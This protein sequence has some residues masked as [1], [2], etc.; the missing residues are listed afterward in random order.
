MHKNKR[1]IALLLTLVMLFSM[2]PVVHAE[3]SSVETIVTVGTGGD[4]DGL[5]NAYKG[6]AKDTSINGG[7]VIFELLGDVTGTGNQNK[8]YQGTEKKPLM[9][10]TPANVDEVEIRL[11]NGYDSSHIS[12]LTGGIVSSYNG[13]ISANGKPFT[14]GP[15]I[16]FDGNLFGGAVRNLNAPLVA[17]TNLKIYGTVSCDVIGGN[18]VVTSMT[19]ASINTGKLDGNVNIDVYGKVLGNI[20]GGSRVIIGGAETKVQDAS[21]KDVNITIH[22]GAE[23]NNVYGAGIA[24]S[25]LSFSGTPQTAIANA[26]N[27]VINVDGKV[28][29][30]FGGGSVISAGGMFGNAGEVY[31]KAQNVEIYLNSESYYKAKFDSTTGLGAIYGGGSSSFNKGDASVGNVKIFIE[32]TDTGAEEKSLGTIFGGGLAMNGGKSTA[33]SVSILVNRHFKSIYGG[34]CSIGTGDASVLGDVDINVNGFVK[35]AYFN[36]LTGGGLAIDGNASVGNVNMTID[37]Y[38]GVGDASEYFAQFYAH[39]VGGGRATSGG[40]ANAK[41]V[42]ILF[43][44]TSGL[45]GVLVGGGIGIDATA[46]VNKVSIDYSGEF[47]TLGNLK[48]G[49]KIYVGGISKGTGGIASL[50]E[51]SLTIGQVVI[52]DSSVLYDNPVYIT[53]NGFSAD[54]NGSSNITTKNPIEFNG[55]VTIKNPP[56]TVNEFGNEVKYMIIDGE[57]T[58]PAYNSNKID[59]YIDNTEAYDGRAHKNNDIIFTQDNFNGTSINTKDFDVK[60]GDYFVEVKEEDGIQVGR[61]KSASISVTYKYLDGVTPDTKLTNQVSGSK[62]TPIIP[63]RTGNYE[64]GGWYLNRQFDGPAWNFNN[65][66]VTESIVLYA[67]WQK[68]PVTVSFDANGGTGTMNPIDINKGDSVNLPKNTFQQDGASFGGWNTRPDG[69]GTH[70]DDEQLIN[71]PLDDTILYAE[72]TNGTHKV[73]FNSNGG[74]GT[75]PSMNIKEGDTRT[76]PACLF[77]RVDYTF[78]GWATAQDG[79]GTKYANEGSIKMG[80]SDITLYAQWKRSY[81]ITYNPN[82]GV[83]TEFIQ[84]GFSGDSISLLDNRF[85]NGSKTFDGWSPDKNA[86]NKYSAGQRYTVPEADTVMYAMW[87]DSSPVPGGDND[88]TYVPSDDPKDNIV[89]NVPD[90]D[91]TIVRPGPTPPSEDEEF[92]EWNTSPD[93]NGDSYKPGDKL[94][95]DEDIIL[96]P[97]FKEKNTITLDSNNGSNDKLVIKVAKGETYTIPSNSFNYTDHI[98]LRWNSLSDGK[99]KDYKIG[100]VITMGDSSIIIY[101]VWGEEKPHDVTYVP[102]KE[103]PDSN[104]TETVNPGDSTIIKPGPTPPSDDEEFLEWNKD[105]NGKGDGFKPGDTLTPDEDIVLYPVFVPKHNVIFNSNNGENDTKVQRIG[106]GIE[107]EL[108]ENTFTYKHH[109]FAGW[110][111]NED[112]SGDKYS[113]KQK[114][115]MGTTDL[116]LY[117]QWVNYGIPINKYKVVFNAN[118]GTGKMSDLVGENGDTV[119]LTANQFIKEHFKF[120]SWNT[121]RDGSGT[122]YGN[123]SVYEIP[124]MNSIL[125]AQWE[126]DSLEITFNSNGGAGSMPNQVVNV[127]EDSTL[128]KNEFDKPGYVFDGWN[129]KP[130][131]S[132]T[133]YVDEDSF[134]GDDDIILYAQWKESSLRVIY[135]ANGALGN[136]PASVPVNNGDTIT[137]ANQGELNLPGSVFKGW[138]EDS[139]VLV[140]TY[141]PGDDYEFT[142]DKS[143][144]LYAI[145][146]PPAK[147]IVYLPNGAIGYPTIQS[148]KI[149]ETLRAQPNH[150]EFPEY[151]FSHWNTSPFN[152]GE[153]YSENEVVNFAANKMYM[154]LYAQ[155]KVKDFNVVYNSNGGDGNTPPPTKGE[156]GSYV[157]TIDNPFNKPGYEFGGW[158]TKADG[159]GTWYDENDKLLIEGDTTLYAQWVK[160]SYKI[161]YNSNSGMGS[162][163]E[164]IVKVGDS[165]SLSP[166]TF[167]RTDYT[168]LYW[169]TNQDGSG[170][171]YLDKQSVVMSDSDIILYAQWN[172][173]PNKIPDPNP[174]WTDD[175]DDHVITVSYDVIYYA[176]DG[177][178]RNVKDYYTKNSTVTTRGSSTFKYSGYKFEGWAKSENGTVKYEAGDKFTMPENNVRLYAVWSVDNTKPN[179]EKDVTITFKPDN[180]S[181]NDIDKAGKPGN[182]IVAPGKDNVYVSSENKDKDLI[183]W[184]DT[185]GGTVKYRPGD[186]ITIPSSNKTYYAV[187][188]D[189]DEILYLNTEDHI[190]YIKGRLNL[191]F[192]P[193]SNMTRAEVTVM[194]SRLMTKQ[195]DLY[196]VYPCY[197]S[198]TPDSAWYYNQL[199]YMQQYGIVRGYPDGTFKPDAPISRAEFAV[200]V[201]RFMAYVNDAGQAFPDVGPY[202]WAYREINAVASRGWVKGRPDGTF[203]PERK[204]TRAEVVTLVN[205]MLNRVGD[206]SYIESHKDSLYDY[207]DI[208]NA[209]WA[210][211]DAIESSNYHDYNR[212]YKDVVETWTKLK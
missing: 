162:M 71:C 189:I 18:R 77:D 37:A 187:W 142:S 60:N 101:A 201:S 171:K 165:V 144:T 75:M 170:I 72:W 93:G 138:D 191:K 65:D 63:T 198:D 211:Y 39:V 67:K 20:Y 122:S 62:L 121:M 156:K 8:D 114:I 17:D 161:Y 186:K 128:N 66:V 132:G 34:G 199:G 13:G 49:G 151:Q 30:V 64:F 173:T 83:G 125:Y 152:D 4:Y 143:V 183:G 48:D 35:D 108:E 52:G 92:D 169:T 185:P 3:G 147:R 166:N 73:V 70:Y 109:I 127:N 192:A 100:D 40:T 207:K 182:T 154:V 51:G 31:A 54:G 178:D 53:N 124:N 29:S 140:G 210:Y 7:K 50:G 27:V 164:Q 86:S 126:R 146:D 209:H 96:Y 15:N 97:I 14:L 36:S 56:T 179:N 91:S 6:V 103:N 112:G 177:T 145:W 84:T 155:W 130:D 24:Q 208:T 196:T 88:V 133:S 16:V 141:N 136:V 131:G 123:E 59:L 163:P 25:S 204:I 99:G 102:D 61:L 90:G 150:Y 188:G 157:D 174:P 74:R 181:K 46:N 33:D 160:N 81:K 47:N 167:T 76:L 175:D 58:L 190:A 42:N 134:T 80:T 111:T 172:Y 200:I 82:G 107:R 153:S 149:D 5:I 44:N 69:K 28:N 11:A 206:K 148:G 110:T 12:I 23:V 129:T 184:S 57:V 117:A 41:D 194:F 1:C 158:N 159:S 212:A 32:K 104:E 95:P 85:T 115:T 10:Y 9:L 197:F 78:M 120:E 19:D 205:R 21:V 45:D 195:M 168:F 119:T 94:T 38:G 68:D 55:P 105:P 106:E 22:S 98:F 118:T 176:N 202:H 2:V 135:D 203:A 137:V 180:N 116:I 43:K 139:E 26:E 87:K 113:D 193:D 89:D 79:S